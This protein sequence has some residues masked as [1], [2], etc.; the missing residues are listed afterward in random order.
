[1]DTR[2]LIELANA[3]INER[4]IEIIDKEKSI[5]DKRN[6]NLGFLIN[7]KAKM[8]LLERD[9]ERLEVYLKEL[10]KGNRIDELKALE[11]QK[12]KLNAENEKQMAEY[13][14]FKAQR[15]DIDRSISSLIQ[16]LKDDSEMKKKIELAQE[17]VDWVNCKKE[18][19]LLKEKKEAT[20]DRIRLEPHE[21][22]TFL[23]LE[24]KLKKMDQL[25]CKAE[26][27][28]KEAERRKIEIEAVLANNDKLKVELTEENVAILAAVRAAVDNKYPPEMD[29][30]KRLLEVKGHIRRLETDLNS[31]AYVKN[32]FL[33]TL[34]ETSN[35]MKQCLL[36]EKDFDEERYQARKLHFE[37][38]SKGVTPEEIEREKEL[39]DFRK[40]YTI[41]KKHKPNIE[42]VQM[43]TQRVQR[44]DE[45]LDSLHAGLGKANH[46]I[47]QSREEKQKLERECYDL[48][49]MQLLISDEEKCLEKLQKVNPAKFADQDQDH[50]LRLHQ[51]GQQLQQDIPSM[52][53][54]KKT[55]LEIVDH[56]MNT[57]NQKILDLNRQIRDLSGKIQAIKDERKNEK[58]P[59]EIEQDFK[60]LTEDIASK[61]E[62][63]KVVEAD[64]ARDLE[65]REKQLLNDRAVYARLVYLL[66]DLEKRHEK[67]L[68]LNTST[69]DE[70]LIM[71]N[72]R[73]FKETERAVDDLKALIEEKS[74]KVDRLREEILLIKDKIEL[75]VGEKSIRELEDKVTIENGEILV[76]EDKVKEEKQTALM[77]S[78]ANSKV[79]RLEGIDEAHKKSAEDLYA[80]IYTHRDKEMHYFEKLTHY[81]YYRLLVE[82]LELYIQS[83]ESAL[84]KYHKE[85]I[86]MINKNIAELWKLT[87]QNGDIKRIE[88]KAEQIVDPNADSKGN[89]HYRVMFYNRE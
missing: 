84:V 9:R 86:E 32:E 49:Q 29:I 55:S 7:E 42:K 19:T 71:E 34:V 20:K 8:Q 46:K 64:L 59:E 33:M 69:V 48:K 26:S 60:S 81:E 58:T 44:M 83:L 23:G 75:E 62:N 38:I 50:L 85:K 82:D 79:S 31:A 52:L 72:Y 57:L 35:E 6:D 63:L 65:T 30:Y 21:Q 51:R 3:Q 56:N 87:Y 89:F 88:I 10:Y 41:L 74:K 4:D 54:D 76:L 16:Q 43:N 2:Q 40:E 53:S 14:T 28:V 36:C 1:M 17:F 61:T 78:E 12:K 68:R 70:N 66:P 80:R 24:E 37:E 73:K 77:L 18:L 13:S 25:K 45:E 39:E 22:M 11:D 67:L 27:D 47:H 15:N 5:V